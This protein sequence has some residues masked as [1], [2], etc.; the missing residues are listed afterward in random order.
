MWYIL[1]F[2]RELMVNGPVS[3]CYPEG[4]V[5]RLCHPERMRRISGL[6]LSR[7]KTEVPLKYWTQ[8]YARKL[9][10]SYVSGDLYFSPECSRFLL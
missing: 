4:R 5:F 7:I 6:G 1:R 8:I 2:S 3:G 9:S 10:F